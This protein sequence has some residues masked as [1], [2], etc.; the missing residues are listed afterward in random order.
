MKDEKL[1]SVDGFTIN[2]DIERVRVLLG[3]GRCDAES[4]CFKEFIY[5]LENLFVFE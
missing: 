4:S 3:K 5:F 2:R 1:G